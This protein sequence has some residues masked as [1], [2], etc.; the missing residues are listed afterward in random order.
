MKFA[1]I[2]GV[3]NSTILLTIMYFV[4]VGIYA[5][6]LKL[7]MFLSW[8]FRKKTPSTYWVEKSMKFDPQ[9]HKYPF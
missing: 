3:I 5:L 4:I 9:S 8:P 1:H 2:L 6:L 7:Y